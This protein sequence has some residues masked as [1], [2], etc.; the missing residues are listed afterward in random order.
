ML[1]MH[2][3]GLRN[4]GQIRPLRLHRHQLQCQHQLEQRICLQEQTGG[5]EEQ[6][7]HRVRRLY[8]RGQHGETR[9]RM[10]QELCP[11]DSRQPQEVLGRQQQ[12][13]LDRPIS[14]LY[15]II[16]EICYI[17]RLRDF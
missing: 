16:V 9:L 5:P 11:E 1:Q 13:L 8:S 12:S 2:Q 7:R 17:H 6:Q 15:V 3:R 14:I 10:R 4:R